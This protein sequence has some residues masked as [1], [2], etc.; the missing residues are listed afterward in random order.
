MSTSP[1][2][3]FSARARQVALAAAGL[4][5]AAVPFSAT[6]YAQTDTARVT[7][8]V[9]DASGAIIPNAKVTITNTDDNSVTVVTSGSDG[10]FTANALRPGHYKAELQVAGFASEVQNFKLDVSQVQALEFH[11]K[12]GSENTVVDVTD[13][14][15][16]VDSTTSSTGIVI[17]DREL[18][19]LP[20]NGRNFTELALL[21]PGITRG[22]NGGAASGYQNGNQPVE[23]IRYNDT[24]GAGLSANGLRPQANNFLL[25]GLDNNESLVNTIVVFPPVEGLS[26]FRVTNTL[27]PAEF[28]RAG[29]AIVQAALKSGTNQIHGSAFVFDRDQHVGGAS[30]NYFSPTVAPIANHRLLFGGTVGGPI[31]K[32]RIFGFGDY[33]GSRFTLPDGGPTINTVPT[34]KMR[35]GDFSELLGSGQTTVPTIYNPAN[36]NQ[37]SPTGCTAFTTVH[38]LSVTTQQQLNATI[39]NGAI[40][41]P[42]TCAQFGTVTAPNVIPA[43]RLN[44]V[45]LNYL[46]AF[47]AANR[48]PINN[49]INN[50]QNIQVTELK[51]NDFDT[52]LDFKVSAKDYVFARYNYGQDNQTLTTSLVG[53]PSGFGSGS[54]NTHPREAAGGYNHTFSPNL[55]NEFRFGYTRPFFGYINPFAGD[56]LSQNLGIPNANRNALLSGGALIG[57]G[58]S[59]ISYTGD[60]GPYEVPQK[61]Y[62]FVDSVSY[63]RGKH[64]LKFGANVIRREVD[65]FQAVYNAKGFFNLNASDYTGYEVSDLAAAFVDN[66]SISDP[67]GYYHTI[68]FETGYFAQDD[69]KIG[70]RL[71]LNLGLRYDLYTH[72][73]EQNNLQS[74]FDISTVSLQVAGKNGNSRSLINTNYNNFAPRIGF[75]YDA[76]GTGKTIIRGGYGIYYFLDRGG[77]G[78][79]LSDNPD[80]NGSSSYS[81]A[82]GYRIALSG[83]A[84]QITTPPPGPYAGNQSENATGN[85]PSATTSVNEAAPTNVSVISYPKNSPTSTIQQFNLQVEQQLDTNTA[86]NISYVGTRA[87]HLFNDINY[88][89]TQLVTGNKFFQAQ[90]LSVTLDE[91]TGSSFYN[92]LQTRL[93]RRLANGLNFTAAYTWSH[94]VDNSTGPFSPEGSGSVPI[95]TSGP[96]L[97]LNRGNSDDDERNF[98]TFSMLAELPFGRGKM[99]G[100]HVNRAVDYA[101]GGWQLSPLLILGSGTP[102]DINV[103]G[104]NVFTRPDFIGGGRIYLHPSAANNYQFLNPAVFAAPPVAS[105]GNYARVGTVHRN[106]FYGP[107]YRSV[108]LSIFKGIP[109]TERVHSEIRGQAYNLFNTPAFGNPINTGLSTNAANNTYFATINGTRYRSEREI[110][111]AYRVTF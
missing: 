16:L 9:V 42:T 92:G 45:G 77:V 86:L 48:T 87:T 89:G 59:E 19:D 67:T 96:R 104:G 75:A 18:S 78:N 27:A 94:S 97:D 7:G 32:D 63:S 90:G 31:W 102:F 95:D 69:W 21:A 73:Y 60:G 98:F 11:A 71:V 5:F 53:L 83:A 111:L 99:I 35:T 82:S 58:N 57:G 17:Q 6:M 64:S 107:G 3:N 106:E 39:D 4:T 51:Y 47:P 46:N 25:D 79:Q 80:F 81:S 91:T 65:F 23:T 72:P 88:T 84:P 14:A 101:I 110:E 55:I 105:T 93:N 100:S 38:G 28:G 33:Q 61:T 103:N 54:N 34:A 41:D 22:Q 40:F 85:L 49:V 66:Y 44:K 24:G 36:P 8:S 37:Y 50:Y 62:Q 10:N 30:A 12:V 2:L 43:G 1:R 20:L 108:N 68:S 56:P 109:I 26:E 76:Y 15:P 13:A 52:R 74:N 70:R 29:G